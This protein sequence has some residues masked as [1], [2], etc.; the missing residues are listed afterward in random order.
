MR[1]ILSA[2]QDVR[3]KV[4]AP[5]RSRAAELRP[6]RRGPRLWG[7]HT[8]FGTRTMP[9]RCAPMQWGSLSASANTL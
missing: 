6:R 2:P 4:L 8:F 3:V 1:D 5:R 9:G 7:A